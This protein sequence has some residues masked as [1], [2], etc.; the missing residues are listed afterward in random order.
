VSNRLSVGRCCCCNCTRDELWACHGGTTTQIDDGTLYS[1]PL[2]CCVTSTSSIVTDGCSSTFNMNPTTDICCPATSGS[3]SCIYGATL[4]I[5]V[6]D[7]EYNNAAC[8]SIWT[9]RMSVTCNNS[10]GVPVAPSGWNFDGPVSLSCE[11]DD[12]TVY[13]GPGVPVSLGCVGTFLWAPV[14]FSNRSTVT[15]CPCDLSEV[16]E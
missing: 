1:W 12:E 11:D 3:P 9:V 6:T 4:W 8:C 14:T 15:N 5:Q 13:R 7:F 10:S 16:P 2:A